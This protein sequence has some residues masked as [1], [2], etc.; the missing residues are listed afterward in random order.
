[1]ASTDFEFYKETFAH[2]KDDVNIIKTSLVEITQ[3]ID[4]GNFLSRT[5]VEEFKKRLSDYLTHE[6]LLHSLGSKLSLTTVTNLNEIPDVI[7]KYEETQKIVKFRDTIFEYLHLDSTEEECLPVLENTKK[8]LVDKYTEEDAMLERIKPYEMVIKKTK[9]PNR[10]L[11]RSEHSIISREIDPDIAYAVEHNELFL[12]LELDVSAYCREKSILQNYLGSGEVLP[13]SSKADNTK[14]VEES[15]SPSE[16]T[17]FQEEKTSLT[18]FITNYSSYISTSSLI[19]AD[20]TKGRANQKEIQQLVKENETVPYLLWTMAR[21][22]ICK[23]DIFGGKSTLID[24]FEALKQKGYIISLEIHDG[25]ECNTFYTL[26]VK[27]CECFTNPSVIDFLTKIDKQLSIPTT[28][29]LP[30]WQHDD[31]YIHRLSHI[32][33]YLRMMGEGYVAWSMNETDIPLAI[34]LKF[35]HLIICSGAFSEGREESDIHSL[36]KIISALGDDKTLLVIVKTHSDIGLLSE[37]LLP[38]DSDSGKV[39]FVVSQSDYTIFDYNGIDIKSNINEI[40]IPSDMQK[41]LMKLAD[42]KKEPTA[43]I[44]KTELELLEDDYVVATNQVITA[45][46][47]ASHFKKELQTTAKICKDS[48]SILPLFTNLGVLTINQIYSFGVC[49]DVFTYT[50]EQKNFVAQS[51]E[52]L[53]QKGYLAKYP[54]F[55]NGENQEVY[56]LSHYCCSCMMMESIS[57][58]KNFWHISIGKHW[59]SGE[60]K[61]NVSKLLDT[62][63][64]NVFLLDYLRH[65]YKILERQDM[66]CVCSSIKWRSNHYQASVFW[67]NTLFQCSLI[68]SVDKTNINIAKNNVLIKKDDIDYVKNTADKIFYMD[69]DRMCLF[70]K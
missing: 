28:I 19:H 36:T 21:E 32:C 50:E 51:V 42:N 35:T 7:R 53:A 43:Q 70:K 2:L 44:K 37:N 27:G 67:D 9:S 46:P 55:I 17:A 38:Q 65:T 39:Y 40:S 52:Y 56:C 48:L 49:M 63:V 3:Q 20:L 10:T 26:S 47:K 23:K 8:A 62:Y 6:E 66:R 22:Q 14:S 25:N 68:S 29:D 64:D 58:L 41:W 16:I 11:T 59:I 15:K 13:C 61:M 57:S 33:D 1:M 60:E 4:S 12:N 24:A 5:I 69:D 54:L 31:L 30:V 34:P 45:Y 18:K